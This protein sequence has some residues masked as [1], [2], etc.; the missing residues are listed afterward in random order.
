MKLVT[1]ETGPAWKL[2]LMLGVL[3]EHGVPALIE[4]ANLHLNLPHLPARLTVP[5]EALD[6]ARTVLAE[7]PAR[8]LEGGRD[9]EVREESPD[10]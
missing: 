6:V 3:E 9:E 8:W 7:M 4:D 10:A 5:E 1:L 2:Q